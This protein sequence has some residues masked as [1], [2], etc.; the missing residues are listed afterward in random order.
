MAARAAPRRAARGLLAAALLLAAA[1]AARAAGSFFEEALANT[2]VVPLH[3]LDNPFKGGRA[4]LADPAQ[5]WDEWK[6]IGRYTEI[7]NPK[8][9]GARMRKTA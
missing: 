8:M 1:A 6:R 7:A 3:L 4:L 9:A 2:T 5:K